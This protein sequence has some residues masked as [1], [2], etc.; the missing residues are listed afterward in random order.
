MGSDWP[1]KYWVT[2]H[3][4]NISKCN[5]RRS[6]GR[7]MFLSWFI[8][9]STSWY[10]RGANLKAPNSAGLKTQRIV[11]N[12]C[13]TF[14]CPQTE[15]LDEY[16][17]KVLFDFHANHLLEACFD[18]LD[19]SP[20]IPLFLAIFSKQKKIYQKYAK[21]SELCTNTQ[22]T[23][24]QTIQILLIH[25]SME[26]PWIRLPPLVS[27]MYKPINPY[28]NI[29][30]HSTDSYYLS[31]VLIISQ[32]FRSEFFPC[33]LLSPHGRC[34]LCDSVNYRVVPRYSSTRT[35]FRNPDI[36][37]IQISHIQLVIGCV[38]RFLPI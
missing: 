20:A 27:K 21:Q 22:I 18:L 12:V 1:T 2:L 19:V 8:D 10:V 33:L 7:F 29:N 6:S 14:K 5:R 25:I 24:A 38:S 30:Y 11:L 17:F 3:G 9:P 32:T 34:S 4:F 26:E 16:L 31:V 28:L 37:R 23:L 35:L 13:D 15:I 36:F